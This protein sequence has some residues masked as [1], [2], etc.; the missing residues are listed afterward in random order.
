MTH[1]Y[2]KKRLTRDRTGEQCGP[3][4]ITGPVGANPLTSLYWILTCQLC[5][6]ELKKASQALSDVHRNNKLC[7]K[8]RRNAFAEGIA[9]TDLAAAE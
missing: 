1:G 3:Y 6:Y 9:S 2:T 4:R 8:C 7:A 5:G